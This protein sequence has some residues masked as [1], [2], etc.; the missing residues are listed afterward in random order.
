MSWLSNL[1]STRVESFVEQAGLV[2]DES[3]L[4]NEQTPQFKQ[5][6]K[7]ALQKRDSVIESAITKE[8]LI[9]EQFLLKELNQGDSYTKRARPTVVYAGLVFIGLNYVLVPIISDIFGTRMPEFELPAEF[10]YGWSGIVG[11]WS[12]GRTLEKRG[13]TSKLV[14]NITGSRPVSRI[15][16]DIEPRA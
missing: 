11:T 9:K 15:L 8:L 10:W 1:F 5:Q 12:I 7:S 6:I 4:S 14:Q 2:A 3:N 16:D 13:A